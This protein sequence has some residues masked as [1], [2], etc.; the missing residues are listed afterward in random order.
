MNERFNPEQMKIGIYSAYAMEGL[1]GGVG[2]VQDNI[3]F[4][5]KYLKAKGYQVTIFAPRNPYSDVRDEKIVHLG[6]GTYHEFNGSRHIASRRPV[7]PST[8]AKLHRDYNLDI[9][10]YEEPILSF[11]SMQDLLTSRAFNFAEFHAHQEHHWKLWWLSQ[12]RHLYG[13]KLTGRVVVS[14]A[15]LGFA[16]HYFPGDYQVIPNGI[17][18]ERFKPENPKIPE[19]TG[20]KINILFLGRLEE[21]KGIKYL[22]EAFRLARLDMDNIRLIIAGSGDQRAQLHDIIEAKNIPDVHLIGNVTEADKPSLYAT[23]DIFCSLATHGESFGIVLLEAMATGKPIVAGD[24]PG[25]RTVITGE[26]GILV[27]PQ[28]IEQVA[29]NLKQLAA[30]KQEREE[31]G[32]AGLVKAQEFAWPKIVD[33]TERFYIEK[34]EERR[35]KKSR[36]LE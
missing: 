10:V 5:A 30:N 4:K 11:P 29:A 15:A 31:R 23:A 21:R 33:R 13:R 6:T 35:Q 19:F 34:I 14:D 25:Y 18:T 24:N 28:N 27:N 12:L 9:A 1:N 22:L 20:G 26:E 36:K 17:D 8:I 32:R 16:K 3:T 2:G 7:W